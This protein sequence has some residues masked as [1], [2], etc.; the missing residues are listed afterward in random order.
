MK[1]FITEIQN[2]TPNDEA[3]NKKSLNTLSKYTENKHITT[4]CVTEKT[5]SHWNIAHNHTRYNGK[6]SFANA[7]Y[8]IFCCCWNLIYDLWF[9]KLQRTICQC[10][11]KGKQ[12]NIETKRKKC[13]VHAED[14]SLDRTTCL[15]TDYLE[16]LLL[17]F[18]LCSVWKW[19]QTINKQRLFHSFLVR[20][21]ITMNHMKLYRFSI[22]SVALLDIRADETNHYF[23]FHVL[24]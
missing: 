14:K 1:D 22:I 12:L 6:K 10:Q 20:S 16:R 23:Y 18:L 9:M 2:N 21:F 24:F 17:L 3:T 5:I 13:G 19:F 11:A 8:K 15:K 4:T 7:F